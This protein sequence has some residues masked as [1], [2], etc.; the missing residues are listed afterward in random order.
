MKKKRFK[1]IWQRGLVF[2]SMLITIPIATLQAFGETVVPGGMVY[3]K[4]TLAGSPYQVQGD[5]YVSGVASLIIESGTSVEFAPGD[6]MSAGL[7]SERIELTVMSGGNLVAQGVTFQSQSSDPG[8]WFGIVV[9]DGVPEPTLDL[10]GSTIKHARYGLDIEARELLPPSQFDG[11][12]FIENSECGVRFRNGS[13]TALN[14]LR[15]ANNTVGICISDGGPFLTNFIVQNN[16]SDGILNTV[17]GLNAAP[18]TIMNATIHQNGGA[19]VAVAGSKGNVSIVNSLVTS[20][21]KGLE[22]RIVGSGGSIVSSYTD[23]FGNLIDRVDVS[24][25]AGDLSVD[26]LYINSPRDLRLFSTSPVINMGTDTGAPVRDFIGVSRPQGC[27]IDMG[28]FEIE[29][30]PPPPPPPTCFTKEQLDQEVAAANAAKDTIIAQ[31]DII[32]ENLTNENNTKA[33]ALQ[34]GSAGLIEIHALLDIAP[35]QRKSNPSYQGQLGDQ[36]NHIIKTLLPNG[37]AK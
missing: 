37:K 21:R 13:Q 27:C 23:V 16:I 29:S 4:W 24:I 28:A 20:N 26:P 3:G 2:M 1:A 5:I 30:S 31:K 6:S 25:G 22:R 10:K 7:D 33:F 12:N 32:I 11:S 8:S 17:G 18:M 19:G 35:G 9:A 36:L 34:Q 14:G 15:V